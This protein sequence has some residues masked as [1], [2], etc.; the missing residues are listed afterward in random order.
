MYFEW[1]EEKNRS[2]K[3]KHGISFEAAKLAFDDP[4][5]LTR[6][7]RTEGGEDRYHTIAFAAGVVLILV[8]HTYRERSGEE[9]VRIISARKANATERRLYHGK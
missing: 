9:V 6:F 7:D 2:N 3:V 4:R 8:V 1:D 5:Q